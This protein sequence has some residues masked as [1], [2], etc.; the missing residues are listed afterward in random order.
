MM[1]KNYP[2][3]ELA[4]LL[5]Q[6]GKLKN[7]TQHGLNYCWA[8]GTMT[9]LMQQ[10]VYGPASMQKLINDKCMELEKELAAA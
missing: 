8:Y 2:V 5:V 4:D 10:A 7:G 6:V 3:H 1:N 9:A